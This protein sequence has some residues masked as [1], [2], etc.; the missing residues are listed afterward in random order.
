MVIVSNTS[1][2]LNL[3]IIGHLNLIKQQLGI[4]LKAKKENQIL[5]VKEIINDLN[6]QA[7]FRIAPNLVAKILRE[8]SE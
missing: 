2:L 8:S 3:A 5:S 7:S 4:I 6:Y 1:P